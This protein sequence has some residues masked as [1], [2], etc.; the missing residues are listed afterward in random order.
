MFYRR[1]KDVSETL[2]VH[3]SLFADPQ[4]IVQKI[5]K[6]YNNPHAILHRY[7]YKRNVE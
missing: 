2:E 3:G 6:P 1:L 7:S 4:N 5:S